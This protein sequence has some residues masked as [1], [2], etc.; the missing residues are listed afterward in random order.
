MLPGTPFD[1]LKMARQLGFAVRDFYRLPANVIG[2]MFLKMDD[3][4]KK[5]VNSEMLIGLNAQADEAHKR[6]AAAH[7]IGHYIMHYD[8]CRDKEN[9]VFFQTKDDE[10]GIE[11]EACKFAAMLLMDKEAFRQ[12]YTELRQSAPNK[13][14]Y[15]SELY[16]IRRLSDIF[17]APQAS[18]RR[19]IQELNLK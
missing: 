10:H 14:S 1:V 5:L 19:R 13:D 17:K 8:I 12:N 15:E 18:V 16:C 9:P 4:M 11:A 3:K 2:F 7:E 6:F